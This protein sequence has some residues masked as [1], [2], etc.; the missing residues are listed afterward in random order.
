[1]QRLAIA[2]AVYSSHPVLMLDE[3]TSSLDEQ[4]EEQLL[5]NLRSMTD[6]TVILVTHRPAAL[7]IADRVIDFGPGEE[8]RKTGE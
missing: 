3:C 5:H 7:R 1:M 2:R 6:K 8:A 4:T